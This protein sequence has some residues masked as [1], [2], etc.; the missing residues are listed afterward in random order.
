MEEFNFNFESRRNKSVIPGAHLT[1]PG[2]FTR[3]EVPEGVVWAGW[4]SGIIVGC[5]KGRTVL[6]LVLER[7]FFY[8]IHMGLLKPEN[9]PA[10]WLARERNC[11]WAEK[12]CHQAVVLWAVTNFVKEVGN[13]EGCY[14]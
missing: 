13:C 11:K 9:G 1:P 5:E 4:P 7:C 3:P 8:T 6:L 10:A 14:D 2:R 12:F